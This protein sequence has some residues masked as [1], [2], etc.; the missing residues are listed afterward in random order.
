MSHKTNVKSNLI[1]INVT[2]EIIHREIGKT[3][4]TGMSD[5]DEHCLNDFYCNVVDDYV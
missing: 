4:F 1:I 2:V 5:A 3:L